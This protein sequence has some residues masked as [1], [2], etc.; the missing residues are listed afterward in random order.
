MPSN[1]IDKDPA[2]IAARQQATHRAET[3]AR[4]GQLTTDMANTISQIPQATAATT[5][6]A[7]ALR[8]ASTLADLA[9]T[10]AQASDQALILAR[11]LPEGHRP[12]WEEL[13]RAV[14]DSDRHNTRRRYVRL[15][16]TNQ[17]PL[18]KRATR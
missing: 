1:P 7:Q 10:A 8:L 5:D 3:A 11:A 15:T 18:R 9:R 12:S 2:V 17:P 6:P 13:A 14:G 16:D 4:I